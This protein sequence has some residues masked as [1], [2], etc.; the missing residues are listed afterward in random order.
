MNVFSLK[1][2]VPWYFKIASKIILRRI[3]INYN[4]WQRIGLFRHGNMDN[5]DYALNL[6]K[7]H[8]S[9]SNIEGNLQNKTLLEIGPGDSIASAIIA[10]SL[11][12]HII[13]VDTGHFADPSIENYRPLIS[14][15]RAEGL[16]PPSL[17][18]ISSL[19]E[20]LDLCDAKYFTDGLNSLREVDSESVDFIYSNAVLE[21]IRKHE[22]LDTMQECERILKPTGT[23]SHQIDLRDHLG[24]SL[25]N[26]RF[27]EKIWESNFLAT[28]GFYTNR[29]QFSRMVE[30]FKSAK[31]SVSVININRWEKLPTP[32]KYMAKEFRDLPENALNVSSFVVLLSK[33]NP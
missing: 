1:S 5:A 12:A 19:S 3:P 15:L 4:F 16:S 18:N 13:L 27:S 32:K 24:G 2:K 21:H 26:L 22:F 6:F 28:S 23:C 7:K 17:Q 31:F 14:K 11:G 9:Q 33:Q 8:I 30:L 20:L 29:I 25:N 10:K